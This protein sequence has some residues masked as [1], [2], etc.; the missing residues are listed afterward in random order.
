M[1][2][3]LAHLAANI[4]SIVLAFIYCNASRRLHYVGEF[5][6]KPKFSQIGLFSDP[7]FRASATRKML[8]LA[9]QTDLGFLA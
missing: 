9:Q 3:V 7:V 8:R 5:N 4:C 1:L 6:K 2:N